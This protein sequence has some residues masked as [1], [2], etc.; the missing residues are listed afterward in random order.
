M[1]LNRMVTDTTPHKEGKAGQSIRGGIL[2][3]LDTGFARK[4]NIYS[5]K[6]TITHVISNVV[7]DLSIQA[8]HHIQEIPRCNR[9]D[10]SQFRHQFNA[11]CCNN[12]GFCV[13]FRP[14]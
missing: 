4:F 3:D 2:T 10:G 8:K 1:C 9:D 7:R 14:F 5:K 6:N 12:I 13:K 11:P